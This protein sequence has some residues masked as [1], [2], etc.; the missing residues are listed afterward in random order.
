MDFF[1]TLAWN[2]DRWNQNNLADF[3]QL[4]AAREF[5]PE[6][7]AEIANIISKYT[8]Y[9]G[10]RKPEFLEPTTFSL[11]NYHEADTVLADFRS[12]AEQAESI[13]KTLPENARDAF[14]ELV[15]YPTKACAN[16][17]ELYVAV[18][19]NRLYAADGRASTNDLASNA[20]ALSQ[21]DAHWLHLLA[22]S[23]CQRHARS[24]RTQRAQSGGNGSCR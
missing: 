20:R 24:E 11:V 10:R 22:R 5:G 15:L 2:P 23:A 19:R 1:L 12:I 3:G 9:N 13:Y 6:H 21:T 18:G 8:K 16:L 4:W 7:A 14:Y 17:T